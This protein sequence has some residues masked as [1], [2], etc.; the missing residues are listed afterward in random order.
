MLLK[1]LHIINFKNIADMSL[2][3]SSAFNCFIGKNGVGKTNI[4]D[5]IYHLSMCKSYFGLSD[6]QNIRHGENFFLLQGSYSRE[7]GSDLEMCYA[8]RQG[9]KKVLKKNGKAYSRLSEHIGLLPL[10]MVAPEDAVLIN[11]GGEERRRFMD[12]IISQYNSDYLYQLIRYNRALAQRNSLLRNAQG[13]NVDADILEIWNM[14]LAESGEII[15]QEREHFIQEFCRLFRDYYAGL[16]LSREKAELN[17]KPSV[18]TGNLLTAYHAAQERDRILMY[19]TLGI[20]RDDLELTI[21]G[22]SV[23]K[24]GSQGQKKTFLVALKLTQYIWLHRMTGLKP[25]LLLDDIF[26]K[27]DA[28]RVAQ[29]IRTVGEGNFGQI[30]VTDTNREHIDVLLKTQASN[31]QIFSMDAGALLPS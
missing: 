2:V 11:G 6:L 12:S 14:Q 29:I 4:L 28:D 23:K 5:A 16:S 3:F 26:D 15:M 24:L 19:T 17:Y 30:F 20:Q 1:E 31:Y 21:G 18:K 8:V 25:L 7:N 9:Q 27:L 13:K 10:V 22:Y